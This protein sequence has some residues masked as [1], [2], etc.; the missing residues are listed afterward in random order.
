MII[1]NNYRDTKRDSTYSTNCNNCYYSGVREQDY[2][3]Y[4]SLTDEDIEPWCICDKFQ[5]CT[6][7]L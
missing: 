2:V 1:M 3:L 7:L 6:D 5:K 4:C